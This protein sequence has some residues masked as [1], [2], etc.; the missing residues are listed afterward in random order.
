MRATPRFVGWVRS[1]VGLSC[2]IAVAAAVGCGLSSAGT[3]DGGI[4]DAGF[5]ATT[6]DGAT[7]DGSPPT[8]DGGDGGPPSADGGDAACPSGL[9]GPA[10][11]RASDFCIDST[12][13]TKAQYAKF[14][15]ALGDGGIGD[16]GVPDAGGALVVPPECSY[17]KVAA[18]LLPSTWDPT[19][20]ALRPV[21]YVDWCDAALYCRWTGKHLCGRRAGGP[22]DWS[23]AANS[24][25]NA[26]YAACSQEGLRT[27]A[28]G[29]NW[30]PTKCRV[31]D[32]GQKP[33]DVASYAQCVGGYPGLFDMTGNVGEWVDQCDGPARGDSCK[34]LG[35]DYGTNDDDSR[36]DA[37]QDR[38]RDNAAND[39]VGF[40]CCY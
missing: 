11:V 16:G 22:L 17:K 14:L 8:P 23:E 36:C 35:G 9:P 28:Y 34:I 6:D 15:G 32:N 30:D 10:L 40:R 21:T 38:H 13:V 25:K 1:A 5:D 3:A 39:W 12:E 4:A 31:D 33:A 37:R 27:W 26:W 18:D 7:S 2:A 24:T 29:A 19:T 20:N